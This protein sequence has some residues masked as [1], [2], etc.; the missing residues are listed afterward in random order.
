[1]RIIC[2]R[3]R[4]PKPVPLSRKLERAA[5]GVSYLALHPMGFSVPR[6]LRSARCALTAPFH[7]HPGSRRGCLFS[8]ALSVGGLSPARVYRSGFYAKTLRGIAPFGVRTF[9]PA[10]RKEPG[11][12]PP[13]QNRDHGNA[14][15][16]KNQGQSGEA[17]LFRQKNR[18][19]FTGPMRNFMDYSLTP[20]RPSLARAC[21]GSPASG[22][23]ASGDAA[24]AALWLQSGEYARA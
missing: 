17:K 16:F 7:H 10:L 15:T 12:S 19:R 3:S 20:S 21:R 2:L 9:L 4:Y 23:R 18:P 14:S 8:V 24:C 1:M 22:A 11:D 5:P 13:F 6:R